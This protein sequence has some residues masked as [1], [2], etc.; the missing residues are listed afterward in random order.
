[1]EFLSFLLFFP[2]YCVL[3]NQLCCDKVVVLHR[4][5]PYLVEYQD[6]IMA[7]TAQI[8]KETLASGLSGQCGLAG[9]CFVGT[10][11]SRPSPLPSPYGSCSDGARL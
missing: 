5:W 9:S 7:R 1:V 2:S 11:R 10:H 3:A 8:S 4:R 6:H